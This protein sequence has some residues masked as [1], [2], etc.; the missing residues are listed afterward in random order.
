MPDPTEGMDGAPDSPGASPSPSPPMPGQPTGAPAGP[1]GSPMLAPQKAVGKQQSG[2]VKVQVAIHALMLAA[3]DV[4]FGSK[5]FE[6]I[7]EAI[8]KLTKQFGKGEDQPKALMPAEIQQIMQ[9]KNPAAMNPALA[10]AI[11]PPMPQGAPAAA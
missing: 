5:E 7:M 9:Q 1:P 11:K 8:T 10:G 3:A 4:G 6:A 2:R